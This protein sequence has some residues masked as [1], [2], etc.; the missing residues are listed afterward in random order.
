MKKLLAII[1]LGL[2]FINSSQADDIR[3]FQI[4]GMSIGD[5]ALDYFSE[6]EIKRG[7]Q[8]YYKSN[9]VVPV[10]IGNK[11]LFDVYDGVQFH[12]TKN[13]KNFKF[14]ELSGIIWFENNFK[15]C[16]KKQEEID[17][18][19]KVIFSNTTR[20]SHRT[21][22]HGA[23]PSGESKVKTIYYDFKSGD[24]MNISCTDWTK[25]MKYRDNLRIGLKTREHQDWI[26][27]KA[28]K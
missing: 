25:K 5:S 11:A 4:E 1:I 26:N 3:D 16:K 12:Y 18:E 24:F 9:E 22:A 10:Y 28:Y 13:D 27:D 23:D 17:V 8:N 21:K 14:I 6:S 19:L 2:C 15:G 7:K 20:A